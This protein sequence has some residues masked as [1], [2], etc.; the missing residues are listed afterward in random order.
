[1]SLAVLG[2]LIAI[3]MALLAL[4][5]GVRELTQL[6]HSSYGELSAAA[7]SVRNVADDVKGIT[8]TLRGDAEEI[9]ATVRAVN[10][11]VRSLV[12]DA[13]DRLY[14]LG[15]LVDVAQDEAEEFVAASV[16]TMRGLRVGASALR[17]SLFFAGRNGLFRPRKKRRSRL[18]RR[19]GRRRDRARDDDERPR[20]RPRVRQRQ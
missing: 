6:L 1:V 15:A 16:G 18:L 4:R 13:E 11:G 17:R 2:L 20:I 3:V 19:D 8:G 10:D 14:R 7:H 9:G 5:K 12:A